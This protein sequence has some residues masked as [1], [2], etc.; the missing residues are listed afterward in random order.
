MHMSPE[1][2]VDTDYNPSDDDMR[3]LLKGVHRLLQRPMGNSYQEG[4]GDNNRMQALTL[5]IVSL[6]AVSGICGGVVM[7]GEISSLKAMVAQ[8]QIATDRRL[9][10]LEQ[11]P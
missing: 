8:W 3:M 2:R 1:V 7:Y 11:R 10:R 5:T 6:L 9:D 4:G